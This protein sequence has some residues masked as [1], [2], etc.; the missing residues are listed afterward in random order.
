MGKKNRKQGSTTQ[1]DLR[2]FYHEKPQKFT[3]ENL[4][5]NYLLYAVMV[6]M[7]PAC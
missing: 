3:I 2:D 5:S 6:S 1:D 4:L 7:L